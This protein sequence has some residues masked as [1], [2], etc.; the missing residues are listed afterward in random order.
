[1]SN[2]L[3]GRVVVITGASRGIGAAT[4]RAFHAAGAAVALAARDKVALDALATDLGERAIA[5]PTDVS[6]ADAVRAMVDTTV[7]TFGR[8]DYAINNAAGGGARPTPLADL[9]IDAFDS[10]LAISLRGVF[11]SM[12]FEI[13]AM[14][15][16]GGGAIV[17]MSSTAGLQGIGGLAGYVTAKHGVIGLTRSA[18]IDYAAQGIRINAIA[19]GP[20]STGKVR[21]ARPDMEARIRSSLPIGRTGTVE[22]CAA[23]MLWLCSDAASFI[24][25]TTIPVDGGMLA[26]M[27][28]YG[29]G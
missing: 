23:T 5:V 20:I 28:P 6:D 22:E 16:A 3:D 17:N 9:P 26:G 2:Q 8:L 19:P 27:T 15:A 21:S 4:A 1:M 13:P 10:A 7:A 11:L 14:L 25:G 29:R 12:H 24:T 18:A